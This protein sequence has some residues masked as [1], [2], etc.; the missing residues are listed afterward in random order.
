MG[1]SLES[2][3]WTPLHRFEAGYRDVKTIPSLPQNQT[4][5]REA[6]TSAIEMAYSN[7]EVKQLTIRSDRLRADR[8]KNVSLA[9]RVR[10]VVREEI[11]HEELFRPWWACEEL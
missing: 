9:M 5:P 11:I 6:R 4:E 10:P 3:S 2:I 8:W 7:H 1:K